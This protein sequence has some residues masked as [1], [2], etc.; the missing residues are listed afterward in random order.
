[1][2]QL[3]FFKINDIQTQDELNRFLASVK[4]LSITKHFDPNA[5]SWNVCVEYDGNQPNPEYKRQTVDYIK[6]LS[7][8]DFAKFRVLRDCRAKIAIEDAVP[9]A[10]VFLDEHLAEMLKLEKLTPETMKSIKGVGEQKILKYADRMIKYY[11]EK[12]GDIQKYLYEATRKH[13]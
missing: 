5:G 9:V 6:I 11:A 10:T 8:E 1:M 3:K 13:V 12:Q 2:L 7:K 4:M